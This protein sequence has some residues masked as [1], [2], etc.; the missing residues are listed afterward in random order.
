M[1]HLRLSAAVM[2]ALNLFAFSAVAKEVN[3]SDGGHRLNGNLELANGKTLADGVIVITHGGLAHNKM[4]MMAYLQNALKEKGYNTL[5]INLSLG[6]DNRHGMYNCAVTHRH[7]NEDAAHE[8]DAWV[9]WLKRDGAKRVAVLGHSRGGAQTALYAAEHTDP[10]VKAVVLMAPATRENSDADDYRERSGKALGPTLAK[11]EALVQAK[12]GDT[13]LKG[14]G[15]MSCA[16]TRATAAS[17]VSYYG[18]NAQVDAPAL[19]PK[20]KQPTL[21][22][23]AGDDEVVP[24]LEPKISSLVDG[25]RVQMKV[26]EGADHFFRDLYTDDAVDTIDAFLKGAGY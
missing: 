1:T 15:L 23:V 5:A 8:I 7:R 2:L 14:V 10:L 13:V 18:A 20:I 25:K 11:A 17:F 19:I 12:K 4:E 22:L 26:I 6:I 21:V 3:V 24:D 16:N 9:A